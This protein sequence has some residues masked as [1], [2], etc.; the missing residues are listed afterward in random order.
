M[1][2]SVF[3]FWSARRLQ[4]DYVVL[5]VDQIVGFDQ[6]CLV[7]LG[8][9]LRLAGAGQ[10]LSGAPPQDR[11]R[12]INMGVNLA[13]YSYGG[14]GGKF[15]QLIRGQLDFVVRRAPAELTPQIGR[16]SCRERV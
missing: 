11:T 2:K 10:K 5:L 7:S 9:V 6:L 3:V 4:L 8:E 13:G 14:R 15:I 16:A 1:Q 12:W